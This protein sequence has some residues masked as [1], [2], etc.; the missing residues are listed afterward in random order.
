[1]IACKSKTSFCLQI[2]FGLFIGHKTVSE[3]HI[4]GEIKLRISCIVKRGLKI[5][6][7]VLD[8]KEIA[9]HISKFAA[10]FVMLVER[11]YLGVLGLLTKRILGAHRKGCKS[12]P[13]VEAGSLTVDPD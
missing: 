5:T 11:P 10:G 4:L 2:F 6:G 9:G 13:L 1:M 3:N 12:A 8:L 7:E